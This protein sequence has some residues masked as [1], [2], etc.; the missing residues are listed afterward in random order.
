MSESISANWARAASRSSMIEIVMMLDREI[1][2]V[3]N[4]AAAA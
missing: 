4:L 2:T 3:S 1:Y